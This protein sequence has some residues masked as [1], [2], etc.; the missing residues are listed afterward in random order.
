MSTGTSTA[1]PPVSAPVAPETELARRAKA[2]EA[3][4]TEVK[5]MPID[6]RTR[7][8]ALKDAVEAFHTAGLTQIVR[9]LKADPRGKELLLEMVDD[10]SIYALFA[11][12]GIVRADL[13]TRVARVV[14]TVRPYTQ[15]HGGD[16]ELVDVRDGIVYVRMAGACNGCSMSA[17]T[18]RNGVEE[19]LRE[20]CPEVTAIE[21]VPTEPAP[22][23]VPLVSIQR[24]GA[25]A[26]W[27]EGPSLDDLVEGKPFRMEMQDGR[28]LV[29]LRFG[30]QVSAFHNECA[31]QG[32][33]IDGGMVDAE[34]RTITCPW[35]GF[36][37]DCTTGEC[38]TAPQAQ[39]EQVPLRLD[40]GRVLVRPS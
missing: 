2:V 34:A 16:V 27:L 30:E 15:S 5:G 20:Q 17:V 36:R 24:G 12:H 22:A 7:A 1:T 11:M 33:P 4:L 35:H 39:L 13:R 18:L 21:V 38:L 29:L 8:T 6:H 14:E 37:F 28:S 31:H 9:T 19:A 26:G 23:A 40:G 3:A 25:N 10:P 32:L